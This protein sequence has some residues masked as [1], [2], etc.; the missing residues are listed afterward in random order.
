[1]Q[2]QLLHHTIVMP[3]YKKKNAL[4]FPGNTFEI[5]VTIYVQSLLPLFLQRYLTYHT[6]SRSRNSREVECADDDTSRCARMTNDQR[7]QGPQALPFGFV[8]FTLGRIFALR[9]TY[10][11][12]P[13]QAYQSTII[14]EMPKSKGD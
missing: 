14:S 13:Y 12:H 2:L 10:S 4:H 5:P 7:R 1:M 11:S 3:K 9:S 8:S 6:R